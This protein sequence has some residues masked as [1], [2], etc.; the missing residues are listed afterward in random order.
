M[1]NMCEL[2]LVEIPWSEPGFWCHAA[3]PRV[4]LGVALDPLELVWKEHCLVALL[5]RQGHDLA[6]ILARSE[7]GLPRGGMLDL[8]VQLLLEEG[9]LLVLFDEEEGVPIEL[10]QACEP[11]QYI[12][13]AAVHFFHILFVEH[14]CPK[15]ATIR[16]P[17]HV[18][19][20]DLRALYQVGLLEEHQQSRTCRS[21][22]QWSMVP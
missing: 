8:C 3:A 20:I 16:W 19:G 15:P 17:P 4:L 14:H 21:L 5:D 13:Q 6:D 7:R 1:Q 22:L 18:Q 11:R 9:V 10:A 2:F 12:G